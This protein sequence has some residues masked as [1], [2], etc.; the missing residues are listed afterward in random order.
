VIRR[1]DPAPAGRW[2]DSLHAHPLAL[3]K[4]DVPHEPA[5]PAPNVRCSVI[6]PAH[7]EAAVIG[8]RLRALATSLPAGAVELIVVANGCSDDTA[9]V[10][11]GVPGV[12]VVELSQAS[13]TA[14]LDAGDRTATLFP[15]IYLDADIRIPG[16]ALLRLAAALTADRAL[17]GS[18]RVVF[19]LS[20]C[21]W[22]VRSFFAVF[23]RLPYTRRGLTG[24]GVYGLSE[25]G[26]QRFGSF[27][28]VVADDL[29]VQRLFAPEERITVDDTFEV[30]APRTLSALLAVRTRVARGNGELA[31]RGAELGVA[32]GATAG[33]T[34]RALCREVLRHP[35]LLVP[36]AVYVAVTAAARRRARRALPG[37][38]WERDDST[39]TPQAPPAPGWTAAEPTGRDGVSR[40]EG[41]QQA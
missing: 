34:A 37:A 2:D 36:A 6:I 35:R 20:G 19:D 17:V 26:R 38:V 4:V 14:A 39:R 30:V 8:D 5:N 15:R 13:K 25:L 7:D 21:S 41:V 32:P 33:G 12:R 28:D 9:A 24:L 22:P 18:P 29:Y 23:Q 1:P 31:G 27:P 16:S 40:L 10:A 11:R 3:R